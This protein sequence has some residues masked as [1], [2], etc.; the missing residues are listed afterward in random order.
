[1]RSAK[2][3]SSDLAGSKEREW[4]GHSLSRICSPS[5]HEDD[6]ILS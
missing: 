4:W 1:M 3:T 2:T 5:G 6:A